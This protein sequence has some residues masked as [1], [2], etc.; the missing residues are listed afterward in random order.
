MVLRLIPL[1][2]L[3]NDIVCAASNEKP[4]TRIL[5]M[6]GNGPGGYLFGGGGIY[7]MYV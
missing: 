7:V 4:N 3:L 6:R 2:L 5:G 1:T